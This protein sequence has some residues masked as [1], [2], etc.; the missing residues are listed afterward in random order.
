MRQG[1]LLKQADGKV[2]AYITDACTQ[3]TEHATEWKIE[4]E[5][6]AELTARTEAAQKAYE[7]NLNRSL[8]NHITTVAKDNALR[9]LKLFFSLFTNYL[10][11]NTAV[12]DEALAAMNIRP[13]I[14]PARYPLPVP[15]ETP[16]LSVAIQH[17]EI[18]VYAVRSDMGQPAGGVQHKP[19]HGFKIRW[20]FDG[21]EA[22]RIELS[23]RLKHI[24]CFEAKDEGRRITL[25][26]AWVNP[27]LQ[28]GPWSNPVSQVIA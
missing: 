9:E 20:K 15:A 13:R 8:R 17:G 10:I 7:A 28:E 18:A 1:S 3:C 5:R 11:G 16:L 24:L 26:I 25:S 14:R 19:Y 2:L 6:L 22:W 21:E 27:R 23:T 12:P 4:P